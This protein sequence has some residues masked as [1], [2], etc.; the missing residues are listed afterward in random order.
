MPGVTI[1]LS[2][3][4]LIYVELDAIRRFEP[5]TWEHGLGDSPRQGCLLSAEFIEISYERQALRHL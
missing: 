1:D 5:N 4:G 3:F 2:A